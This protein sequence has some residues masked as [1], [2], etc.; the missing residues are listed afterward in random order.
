MRT[1]LMWAA[2]VAGALGV[3]A[4]VLAFGARLGGI[5]WIGGLQVGTLL[6]AGMAAMLAG[7][8]AY[9]AALAERSG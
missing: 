8:L 5:Y 2:R 3:V 1:M 6:Q 7:C 4:M 9:L